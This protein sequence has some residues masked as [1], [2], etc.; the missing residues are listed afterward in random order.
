MP[1]GSLRQYLLKQRPRA[2][3][4]YVKMEPKELMTYLCDIARGMDYISRYKCVH[5]DLAAR[6]VLLDAS[7]P[8]AAIADF[9]LTRYVNEGAL[10]FVHCAH[11]KGMDYLTC[12]N[13]LCVLG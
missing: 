4:E 10:C 3:G 13:R 12:F 1:D 11:L 8:R 6:N 5:R 9:G 7:E 2:P